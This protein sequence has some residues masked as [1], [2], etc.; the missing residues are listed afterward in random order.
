[1]RLARCVRKSRVYRVIRKDLKNTITTAEECVVKETTYELL[2]PQKYWRCSF[3]RNAWLTCS[4]SLYL[5]SYHFYFLSI[6]FILA[7]LNVIGEMGISVNERFIYTYS[8]DATIH[9]W[10]VF[11]AFVCYIL[12]GKQTKPWCLLSPK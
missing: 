4:L 12:W 7:N 3:V 10:L 9:H 6:S 8:Q 11:V 2:M 1:M 5:S